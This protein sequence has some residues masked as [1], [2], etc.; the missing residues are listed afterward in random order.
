MNVDAQQVLDQAKRLPPFERAELLKSLF[1][2]FDKAADPSYRSSLG[3]GGGGPTGRLSHRTRDQHAR[4]GDLWPDQ[5]RGTL[6]VN[7]V[8][9]AP[10]ERELDEAI[11]YYNQQQPGLGFGFEFAVEVR[12]ALDRIG[13]FPKP[14]TRSR[15]TR[16]AVDSTAFP[17]EASTRQAGLR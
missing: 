17:I 11:D 2:T 8:F 6:A 16:A 13:Q 3:E 4:R 12:R 10:A 14:G 1:S 7:V 5:P 15:R 9:L